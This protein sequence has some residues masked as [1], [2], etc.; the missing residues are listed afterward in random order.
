[1]QDF[2]LSTSPS[3]I[4]DEANVVNLYNQIAEMARKEGDETTNRLFWEILE[5]EE[6]HH[7]TCS[8]LVEDL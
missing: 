7:H 3:D 5:Q 1:M 2:S 8:T 4:Q 6:G